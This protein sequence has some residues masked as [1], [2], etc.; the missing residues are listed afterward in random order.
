M[1]SLN[2]YSK[3]FTYSIINKELEKR[4]SGVE[5]PVYEGPD[6]LKVYM[7]LPYI[8][9]MSSKV[10]EC[11]KKGLSGKFELILSNK[12]SKLN[13]K[14]TFKDRQPKHLKSDLVYE[15]K[16]SCGRRYVGE[17][18]RALKTRFDEHMK[19]EGSNMTEV[20]KHL[21]T[22]P[23]CKV[24][25][26]DCRVLTYES[27]QYR[28]KLKESLHIQQF[29]DE[30]EYKDIYPSA[31][32]IPVMYGLPKIHKTGAPLRPILSMAFTVILKGLLEDSRSFNGDP[33]HLTLN[34]GFPKVGVDT[35]TPPTHVVSLFTN[36][37]LDET[38]QL[39]VDSLYPKVPGVAAKDQ[40]FHGAT[41]GDKLRKKRRK[42]SNL[43][44][45]TRRQL[46]RRIAVLPSQETRCY[47]GALRIVNPITNKNSLQKACSDG[48][49]KKVTSFLEGLSD[50]HVLKRDK[51]G[52]TALHDAIKSG[53]TECCMLLLH[54]LENPLPANLLKELLNLCSPEMSTV[55]N[56]LTGQV[57]QSFDFVENNIN[58]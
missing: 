2:G 53:N 51:C 20:G 15:I 39:I 35:T 54:H 6:R 41:D 58:L 16:C 30:R 43:S 47:R 32:N 31:S 38:I 40:L 27:N 13:Q 28:R 55:V 56:F 19:T 23:S 9:D 50:L 46:K 33:P 48:D 18:C 3:N 34:H 45:L 52:E 29:D 36:I 26:E 14:F 10:K 12:Y 1:L 17:T 22:N 21:H 44:G 25:F 5:K 7:K 11:I 24:T 57:F 37:P 4:L 49:E 8:G 42:K